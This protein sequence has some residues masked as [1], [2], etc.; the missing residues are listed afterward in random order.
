MASPD[1]SPLSSSGIPMAAAGLGAAR[2]AFAKADDPATSDWGPLAFLVGDWTGDE[3][4]AMGQGT[5]TMSFR[6][7]LGGQLM[8]GHHRIDYPPTRKRTGTLEQDLLVIQRDENGKASR[9]VMFEAAGN[10]THYLIDIAPDGKTIIYNSARDGLPFLTRCSRTC[11]A[12]MTGK[13]AASASHRISSCTSANRSQPT[14][15]ARSRVRS[16]PRAARCAC[17][18]RRRGRT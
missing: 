2:G 5:A 18:P 6:S 16:S 8:I 11:V 12:Q 3:G 4:G 10:E 14:S 17:R 9:A 13:C 15:T 1:S 7:D